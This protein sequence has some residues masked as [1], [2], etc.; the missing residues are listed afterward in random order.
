MK[1]SRGFTLIEL[2]V[3]IS[4]IALLLSILMPALS[5]VKDQA[6][7]VVCMSHLKQWGEILI[8]YTSEYNDSFM[9][10]YTLHGSQFSLEER[11]QSTWV[12][13][14]RPYYQ[15]D[16]GFL[17]CPRAT[18]PQTEGGT[19]PFAAWGVA[20]R[21]YW[22][23]LPEGSYGSY[24]INWW[25]NNAHD[26]FP[27]I[28]SGSPYPKEYFWRKYSSI[29]PT[30][31][32]PLFLDSGHPLGRPRHDYDEPPHYD[33]DINRDYGVGRFC[34]SRHND[35]TNGVFA[36]GS[37]R[38]IGLKELWVLKWSKGYNTKNDYTL[39]GGVTPDMWPEW[40]RNMK[41]Y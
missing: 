1:Q 6:R 11:Q 12:G 8:L 26:S 30:N 21:T 4:I 28:I 17:T 13:A 37:V 32:V 29:N 27:G 3:V 5:R 7:K 38:K 31:N 41:A 9:T 34:T 25:I 16:D 39:K 35:A 19:V 20:D 40:I 14:L 33:G 2:L 23:F 36:D 24:G 10:G 18:K 15:Y 22:T